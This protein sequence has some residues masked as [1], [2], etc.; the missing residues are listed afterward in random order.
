MGKGRESADNVM[1]N[2]EKEV[3]YP[4]NIETPNA[5][6]AQFCCDNMGTGL[7]RSVP[8]CVTFYSAFIMPNRVSTVVLNDIGTEDPLYTEDRHKEASLHL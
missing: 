8:P 6:L 3:Q 2:Y 4:V 7:V 1:W 5:K